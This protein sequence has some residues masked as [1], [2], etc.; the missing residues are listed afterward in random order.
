M[1]VRVYIDGFN[2]YY[3]A[4][5]AVE[6]AGGGVAWKWLDLEAMCAAMTIRSWPRAV[7]QGVT[8]FTA[9]ISQRY[10]GDRTHIRQDVYLRAL[11][12]RGVSVVSGNFSVQAKVKRVL[13][14]PNDPSSLDPSGATALVQIR[15]EKGSDVNLATAMLV[16][17]FT[18][19]QPA[20]LG[21]A[22]DATVVLSNDSDLLGPVRRL[23]ERGWPVGVI[24]P[25]R[26]P[27]ALWSPQTGPTHFGARIEVGD[28]TAHQL[29]DPLTDHGGAPIVSATGRPI[30]KPHEW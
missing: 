29:P 6:L 22:F 5:E 11:Q 9:R 16:D 30:T 8:Y 15:E 7:V 25:R 19:G 18:D 27:S 21:Q 13:T 3:G 10:P 23:R 4:K 28:L 2:F 14:D 1:R 24:N 12:R 20:G 26:S 17:Y